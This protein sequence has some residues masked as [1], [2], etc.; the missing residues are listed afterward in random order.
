VSGVE[1]LAEALSTGAGQVEPGRI[2]ELAEAFAGRGGAPPGLYGGTGRPATCRRERAEGPCRPGRRSSFTTPTLL[3]QRVPVRCQQRAARTGRRSLSADPVDV[4]LRRHGG[5]GARRRGRPQAGPPTVVRPRLRAHCVRVTR[6]AAAVMIGQK[7]DR[8]TGPVSRTA[9]VGRGRD[10]RVGAPFR[11]DRDVPS[12]WLKAKA[13]PARRR[14]A[15]GLS[16]AHVA[17]VMALTLFVHEHVGVHVV[18]GSSGPRAR[19]ELYAP[20]ER[21]RRNAHRSRQTAGRARR[22]VS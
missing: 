12:S 16:A 7:S 13:V 11:Y 21:R 5:Q 14:P 2:A 6:T 15:R 18:A 20:R 17:E 1:Q 9:V 22:L 19:D 10:R 3:G 4:R 8:A